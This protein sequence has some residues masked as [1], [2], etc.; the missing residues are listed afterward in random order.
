MSFDAERLSQRMAQELRSFQSR[1]LQVADGTRLRVFECGH[2]NAPPLIIVNPIGIPV[3]LVARLAQRLSESFRVICWEQRGLNA[4]PDEFFARPHGFDAFVSDLVE[5][6]ALHGASEAHPMIGVCSGA[7]QLVRATAQGKL[8]PSSLV[9][10]SPQLRFSE[11]YVPSQFEANVMPYMRA[12]AS[13]RLA[14][15]EQLLSLSKR[16]FFAEGTSEDVLLVHAADSSNLQSLDTLRIYASTAETFTAERFDADLGALCQSVCL[17][18]ARG[19][20]V[21]SVQSVRRLPTL[22]RNARYLEYSE[23]GHHA[24]FLNA[25]LREDIHAELTASGTL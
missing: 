4:T 17:V 11:G 18:S 24:T 14:V 23:G 15:A 12:I 1:D 3:L 5:I 20:K 25:R 9:L 8:S 2:A 7:A 6:A 13:G 22:I 19:D 16:E 10:I 21:I